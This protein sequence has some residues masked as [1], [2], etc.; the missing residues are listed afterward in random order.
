MGP[1]LQEEMLERDL[2]YTD[3]GYKYNQ[4]TGMGLL[5]TKAEIQAG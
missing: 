1:C 2:E 3:K 4:K 5:E